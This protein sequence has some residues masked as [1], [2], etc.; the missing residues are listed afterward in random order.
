[1][2]SR[3]LQPVGSGQ[4][5]E[6]TKM[7]HIPFQLFTPVCLLVTTND[8]GQRHTIFQL[9]QSWDKVPKLASN[10]LALLGRIR[11]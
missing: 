6:M 1:M 4:G 5:D 7:L 8:A 2:A 10:T 9:G 3:V 11:Q